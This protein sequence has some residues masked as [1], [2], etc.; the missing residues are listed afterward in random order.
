MMHIMYKTTVFPCKLLAIRK[1]NKQSTQA[2]AWQEQKPIFTGYILA[3][4][5]MEV[6]SKAASLYLDWGNHI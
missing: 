1:H 3:L 5:W 2:A 6:H 4:A